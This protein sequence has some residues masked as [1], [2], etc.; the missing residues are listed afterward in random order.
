MA[1]GCRTPDG[2]EL[3]R[4]QR[5][6]P[7]RP[8]TNVI[9]VSFDALRPDV[10][11]VYGS[12]RGL[13]PHLDELAR[14]SIVFDEAYTVA[15]VTPTSFA[16]AFTGLLP[17]RVF[18]GWRLAHDDT[19]ARR[20]A[21]AGYRTAAFVNNVQLTPAR[22]F[23]TGFEHYSWFRHR[24]DAEVLESSSA[25]LAENRRE[26]IFAWI[27]FFTPHAP[28]DYREAA[29]HLYDAGY[30]GPFRKTTGPSFDTDDPR[31]LARIKSLY[32]GE[33]LAADELL[34]R[35]LGKLQTLGLLATSFVVVTSDHGEELKEHGG[36][37]HG[38][39]TE[40]HVR[41]PLVVY[42]PSLPAPLRSPVL[43]SN[44]DLFPTLA[45]LAGIELDVELDGRDLTRIGTPPDWIVGVS[46]TGARERWLSLRRGSLKLIRTCLAQSDQQGGLALYDLAADPGESRD[47]HRELRDET[48]ELQR[49]LRSV[50][51]ERPC[52]AMQAAATGGSPTAGLSAENVEELEALGYLETGA[53]P[54]DDDRP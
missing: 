30:D 34:G 43:V 52:A 24:P 5:H 48:R 46:M 41:V 45:S 29:A 23:D 2:V 17:T 39:L 4:L 32:E 27:H 42:H 1:A 37:Q 38:R 15:P 36:F 26:R 22:S 20:F 25:W 14:R 49:R 21:D 10:L 7:A 11:G 47:L 6:L 50:V 18:R 31:E 53:A 28:Y 8:G 3:R 35:L 44:V 51:G 33:V 16:A 19:L 40:E 54:A 13:S 12:P 9:V